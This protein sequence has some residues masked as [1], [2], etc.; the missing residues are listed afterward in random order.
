MST[1]TP[2]TGTRG[3]RKAAS[4]ARS[5]SGLLRER[6]THWRAEGL[7]DAEIRTELRSE[8]FKA[9]DINSA[10][11]KDPAPAK[12]EPTPAAKP[13]ASSTEHND[14]EYA[15]FRGDDE[16]GPSMPNL[17]PGTPAGLMLAI[18]LYPAAL[19]YLTGGG[20]NLK[21]WFFAKFFN[22]TPGDP[23]AINP[24]AY[25]WTS[26]AG[27][28][29][30]AVAGG[31]GISAGPSGG[32][33]SSAPKGSGGGK[34]SKGVKVGKG[35]YNPVNKTYTVTAG[36]ITRVYQMFKGKWEAGAI[37]AGAPASAQTGA[38]GTSGKAPGGSSQG[39][40]AARWALG[41]LGK[42]YRWGATGP[43][44]FDCSG[45]TSKAWASAGVSIPRTTAGQIFTGR[46]VAKS[47]LAPGDLV[48]PIRGHVQMYIGG[49]EIV[50]AAHPGTNV[51]T[52]KLGY[53]LTARRPGRG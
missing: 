19:A 24:S 8:G 2:S 52:M 6:I 40:E 1:S 5:D 43:S 51:R 4:S 45:L 37:K 25:L 26:G 34:V 41:Q 29:S 11:A 10:L 16:P 38:G 33:P 32:D 18:I 7:S 13:P 35:R 53:V 36:G 12:S 30:S 49:G 9:A 17:V 15:G 28:T 21:A 44:S 46:H 47:A 27:A 39:A 42:P 48:F 20:T 3:S 22:K 50:E 31:G 14:G 23:T